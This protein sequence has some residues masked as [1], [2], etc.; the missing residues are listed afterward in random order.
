MLI[1]GACV[2]V[3]RVSDFKLVDHDPLASV[4]CSSWV[5]AQSVDE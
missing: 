4:N 3:C 2:S 5:P 1:A